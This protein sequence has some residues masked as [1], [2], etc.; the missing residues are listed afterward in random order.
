MGRRSKY[1]PDTFPALAEKYAKMGLVDTQIAKKLGISHQTMNQY[2][3]KYPDFLASL[4]RGKTVPDDEVENA[5][6]KSAKGYEFGYL[7]EE[8]DAK[9]KVVKQKRGVTHVKPNTTAQIFWL[10]NRRPDKWRDK[11]DVDMTG[12]IKIVMDEDDKKV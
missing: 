5:L 2:K 8:L 6:L 1:D 10:K 3:N 7:E 4:K 9:G 11:Q 12:E